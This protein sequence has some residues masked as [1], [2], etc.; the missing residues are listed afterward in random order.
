MSRLK[1]N[2]FVFTSDQT[3]NL[4]GFASLQ[5]HGIQA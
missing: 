5:T 1:K 2:G 3:I 4:D